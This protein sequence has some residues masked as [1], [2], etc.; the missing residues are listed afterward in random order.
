MADWQSHH[1][2]GY[3]VAAMKKGEDGHFSAPLISHIAGNL[4][5][6]GCIDGVRL[7]D[8]FV[9]VVSLYKWERYAMGPNT[10]L[11]EYTMYDASDVPEA[12]LLN[13]I[14][15]DVNAYRAEGKTLVHCQA[16]L[17]RSNLITAL[18][19]IRAGMEPAE[20]IAL[21]RARR[22]PIVLCNAS[23]ETWLLSRAAS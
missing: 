7:D 20:A 15:D 5:V 4:Y 19:L 3:A 6:G 18:A 13:K 8:D 12:D 2:E 1:I 21:L 14:A 17:N 11:H 23:F 22:S 10:V 9:H 16:G